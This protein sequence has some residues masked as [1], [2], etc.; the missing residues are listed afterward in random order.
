MDQWSK[1]L[2]LFMESEK[3]FQRISFEISRLKMFTQI[4]RNLVNL[5]FCFTKMILCNYVHISRFTSLVQSLQFFSDKMKKKK[6]EKE[7]TIAHQVCF[8]HHAFYCMIHTMCVCT[9][10]I[11]M[12]VIRSRIRFCCTYIKFANQG[13]GFDTPFLFQDSLEPRIKL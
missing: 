13:K 1:F 5:H 3:K 7:L 8:F 12:Y 2:K 11:R 4:Q 9:V 10:Y 6:E